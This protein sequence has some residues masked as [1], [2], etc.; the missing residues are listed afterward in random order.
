MN[1]FS[2]LFANI[3]TLRG[4][5]EKTRDALLRLGIEKVK[6]L[7]LY[8]PLCVDRK[9]YFT[10]NEK[11]DPL[12]TYI[13][14]IKITH[15]PETRNF[16]VSK[17]NR[18]IINGLSYSTP[19]MLTFFNFT[20]YH[21]INKIKL[22]GEYFFVGKITVFNNKLQLV[23]PD[24][25]N[26]EQLSIISQLDPKYSLTYGI[27]SK[28]INNLAEQA[29]IKI[30][31]L[32]EWLPQRILK[33]LNF[34]D[35]AT[36]LKQ[37]H[38][39]EYENSETHAKAIERLIFDELLAHHLTIK[40]SK[41]I[42]QTSV[43][44]LNKI[45]H[46]LIEKIKLHLSFKLTVDQEKVLDDIFKDISKP[47]PMF[48]LLQGDVGSGKTIVALISMVASISQGG[49]AVIMAPTDILAKQH[50]ETFK[51]ILDK[52]N[53]PVGLLKSAMPGKQKQETIKQCEDG[54]IRIVVGTHSLIQDNIIF[55]DLKFVVIDEQH[56]FGV[57]QRLSLS[58]KG[59]AVDTVLMTA[60]P[61]PRTL[62]LANYGDI[63]VS[64]IAVKPEGR[65]P[66]VTSSM[67]IERLEELTISL[68]KFLNNKQ[69]IYWICPLVE[70]IDTDD[71]LTSVNERFDFLKKHF[72][73]E[74]A[75][76]HG[77]MKN[78]EKN[79]IMDQFAFSDRVNI[80][81]ATTVV[82]V[83]V[84]VPSATCIII[85]NAE[86]FGLAQLHQLRGRVGRSSLESFCVLLYGPHVSE[87]ARNRIKAMK[88]SNDGFYLS[89]KDLELR[90]GGDILGTKQSGDMS[91][92]IAEF[93]RDSHLLEI[94]QHEINNYPPQHTEN[95]RLLLEIFDYQGSLELKNG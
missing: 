73:T 52:F 78:S 86:K 35:F 13:V 66:I 55:K 25:Y 41:S 89:E 76:V 5:G 94:A 19:I 67:S 84:N 32:P 15:I 83:G 68:K 4:V 51:Q 28:M 69:K 60:T 70:E 93:P 22:N 49:Q 20:P 72:G 77:Q 64:V 92:R 40:I 88:E 43:K 50:F 9:K 62:M 44:S 10:E 39:L 71:S 8:K 23:H 61:I 26:Q 18:L 36:S 38:F 14:P 63:D 45:D 12:T 87:T 91:F 53:I 31:N 30:A 16:K 59:E 65:K 58:Q 81:V 37:L 2:F 79:E 1:D 75:M 80:L 56:R 46:Q 33:S 34:P 95:L 3:D 85:E 82:E 21:I 7:L 48:R 47:H 54:S 17:K 24:F 57:K 29:I 27:T 11:V 74:V 6:D 42:S 90:G